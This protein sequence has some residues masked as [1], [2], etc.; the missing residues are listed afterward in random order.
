MWNSV[1]AILATLAGVTLTFL[2]QR[3][4]AR[5]ARQA[6]RFDQL[7]SERRTALSTLATRLV[8][9]R[10]AQ[11]DRVVDRIERGEE[12]PE[13][14]DAVRTARQDAW[15]S[16]FGVALITPD[17][18]ILD[19]ATTCFTLIRDLKECSTSA[20]IGGAGEQ[21]RASIDTL[22]STAATALTTAKR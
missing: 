2:L 11:L 12:S 16:Y 9:Y 8:I 14:A 19:R 21:A 18:L 4:T 3:S 10:R 6:A 13:L 1:I 7:D 17:P 5:E 22:V 15:S 20:E